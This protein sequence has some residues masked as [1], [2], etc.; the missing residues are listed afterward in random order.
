MENLA[1]IISD[2]ESQELSSE[3]FP[4]TLKLR[5]ENFDDEKTLNRFIKSCET[6]IRRAPEYRVWTDYIREVLGF[7]SCALTGEVHAQTSV[8]VHHHPVGLYILTKSVILSFINSNKE[9]CSYD[10]CIKVIE[11]HYENRVGFIP[12]L[13]SI[14]QKF[15]NGFLQIP[16][17]LIHGEYEHLI[18][19]YGHHMEEDDLLTIQGRLKINKENC[20]WDKQTWSKEK[21]NG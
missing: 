2:V 20:G 9:F 6:S 1:K 7:Y 11:L 8:D 14:H 5:R 18:A 19:Q 3:E 15:H 17:E 16:I 10:V 4:Y 13:S 21:Y 12:L